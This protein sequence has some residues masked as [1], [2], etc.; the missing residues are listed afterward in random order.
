LRGSDI[1][2]R[3]SPSFKSALLLDSSLD[4]NQNDFYDGARLRG[5]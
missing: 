4:G 5:R 3:E 2:E 1:W